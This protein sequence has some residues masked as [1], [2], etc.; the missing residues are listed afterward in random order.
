[1]SAMYRQQPQPA[2]IEELPPDEEQSLPAFTQKKPENVQRIEPEMLSR[3]EKELMAKKD[4]KF[5]FRNQEPVLRA[6]KEEP[7]IVPEEIHPDPPKDEKV[8][9]FAVKLVLTKKESEEGPSKI[10]IQEPQIIPEV[11]ETPIPT[12]LVQ[13]KIETEKSELLPDEEIDDP[14]DLMDPDLDDYEAEY[15]DDI[16]Y[17]SNDDLGSEDSEI[18]DEELSD[19]DDSDLLKRLEAKYGK[20]EESRT[21]NE[22]D[23]DESWTSKF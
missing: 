15:E 9:M 20:I 23:E 11:K 12:P 6:S 7:K 4:N 18:E 1:M 8:D 13:D 17:D 5:N 3:K 22:E 10:Q 19:V 21:R 16:E 14:D 2:I